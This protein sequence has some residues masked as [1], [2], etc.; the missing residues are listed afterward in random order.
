MSILYNSWGSTN[1]ILQEDLEIYTGM[2]FIGFLTH[3]ISPFLRNLDSVS[4][5]HTCLIIRGS[6]SIL[7][8]KF[9]ISAAPG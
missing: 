1:L 3:E 5:Q 4:L 7:A 9:N 8:R 6:N 2:M